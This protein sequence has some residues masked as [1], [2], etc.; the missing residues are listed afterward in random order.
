MDNSNTV[1]VVPDV[2][3]EPN[4]LDNETSA[5]GHEMTFGTQADDNLVDYSLTKQY[6]AQ[7]A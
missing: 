2:D 5:F 4:F 1:H 6:H 7:P 3:G